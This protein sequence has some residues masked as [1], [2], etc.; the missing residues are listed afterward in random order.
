MKKKEKQ[1]I[2]DRIYNKNLTWENLLDKIDDEFKRLDELAHEIS[3]SKMEQ[4][5]KNVYLAQID[6]RIAELYYCANNGF[7][8]K[9]KQTSND[10]AME[11]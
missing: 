2:H 8:S 11:L 10:N 1:T 5:L 9:A 6:S 7:A 3:N 4:S